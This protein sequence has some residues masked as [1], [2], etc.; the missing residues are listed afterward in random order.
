MG[1]WRMKVVILVVKL[2]N[3]KDVGKLKRL[4]FVRY[5]HVYCLETVISNLKCDLMQK[6]RDTFEEFHLIVS[7][8]FRKRCYVPDACLYLLNH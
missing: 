1:R 6:K 5:F 7:G 8:S 2:W 3:R 4:P